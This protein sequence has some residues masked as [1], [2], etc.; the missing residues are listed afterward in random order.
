MINKCYIALLT[1]L[2]LLSLGSAFAEGEEYHHP[3]AGNFFEAGAVRHSSVYGYKVTSPYGVPKYSN[4][5]FHLQET[6]ATFFAFTA[7]FLKIGPMVNYTFTPYG[8]DELPILSGMER[9]GYMET[10]LLAE[11][12]LPFG[13][14]ELMARYPFYPGKRGLDYKANYA[15]ALP[16]FKVGGIRS[17][18]NFQ[19]EL[20][21]FSPE[22]SRYFFGVRPEESRP[23]RPAH[24]PGRLHAHSLV[25]AYWLPLSERWWLTTT[26]KKEWHQS[27]IKNSPIVSRDSETNY[28]AGLLYSF[29]TK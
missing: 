6:H 7:P 10:G 3:G 11:V 4:G 16:A 14:I 29:G 5:R 26:A 20:S 25:V 8:G 24:D 23:G 15:S 17:W 13:R 12:P 28:L 21:F 19:Y 22:T 1:A 27:K 18:V 2:L 9:S